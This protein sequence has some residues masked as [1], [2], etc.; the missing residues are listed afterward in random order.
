[1][2][3]SRKNNASVVRGLWMAVV[4][5]ALGCRATAA[6]TLTI[7]DAATGAPIAGALATRDGRVFATDASGSVDIAPGWS[8]LGLR[9]PGY[10]RVNLDGPGVS[11]VVRLEPL[12]PRGLYLSVHGIG[13]GRLRRAAL[14]TVR[15]NRLNALVVD[16]KGDRG[17]IPFRVDLPLA[18][19]IG[20]QDLITVSDVDTLL[21]ELRAEGLY[22]IARI[23][24][25][26]DH[27]LA[28]ARPLWQVRN[29]SGEAFVDN[30][31]L[32]WVDPFRDEAWPYFLEV[33]RIAAA[34]GFDEIQF[35]YLRFPAS[36]RAVYSKADTEAG[37]TRAINA[38]LDAAR[39][40][41]APYNVN[42]AADVFGYA[43]WN[44]DDTGV[45]QKIEPILERVD[46]V[47]PMLYPSGFHLGIPNFR[48]PVRHPY[49]IVYK[50][51]VRGAERTGAS[52][53]RFRPW[54]QA[55]RDYAFDRRDFGPRLIREQ[56]RAA[57][58]FGAGGWLLWNPRNV[59]PLDFSDPSYPDQDR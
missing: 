18:A 8:R 49:E 30:E 33:A 23:V 36:D 26:K 17:H 6:A 48:N 57:D 46:V 27:L 22:L 38:F 29:Q 50:T 19:E 31:D 10:G 7:V 59:Y 42:L 58:A 11:A 32:R 47:S 21:A 16:V 40:T 37:R 1:M 9:A 44:R 25:F 4:I 53:L 52:P 5:A 2:R 15:R 56:I 41:L 12:Q 54:L 45:G 55:F 3:S 43:L 39:E 51:L 20:A 24:V 35:D 28:R 34:L 14:E 13:S